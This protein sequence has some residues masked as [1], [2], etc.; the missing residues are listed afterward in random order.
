LRDLTII[1]AAGVH[2][3]LAGDIPLAGDEAIRRAPAPERAGQT[4]GKE[5][6]ARNGEHGNDD[7]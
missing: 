2:H 6:S 3:P 5:Q 4:T 7:Q 1:T